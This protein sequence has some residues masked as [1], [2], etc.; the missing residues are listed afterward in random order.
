MKAT[1][2]RGRGAIKNRDICDVPA[3]DRHTDTRQRF[4]SAY[5]AWPGPCFAGAI[6]SV[7]RERGMLL[8][9]L[10]S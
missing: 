10:K 4:G 7:S 8:H 2:L 5:A 1:G 9:R 6:L 3:H